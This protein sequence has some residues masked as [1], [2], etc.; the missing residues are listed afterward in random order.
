MSVKDT[1]QIWGALALSQMWLAAFVFATTAWQSFLC[2]AA[3]FWWVF[4]T[5]ALLHSANKPIPSQ[6]A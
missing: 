2:G 4:M 6:G 3:V 1:I 5:L